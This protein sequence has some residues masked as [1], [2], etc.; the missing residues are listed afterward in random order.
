VR[1]F[2]QINKKHPHKKATTIDYGISIVMLPLVIIGTTTGVIVNLAFPPIILS[3]LLG[4]LL[5]FLTWSSVGK[6]R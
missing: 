5:L 6:A 3:T 4:L 1:F 2:Y